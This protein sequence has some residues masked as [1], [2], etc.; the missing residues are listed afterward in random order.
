MTFSEVFA[1][2]RKKEGLSQNEMAER[3][4]VTR[5]AVSRWEC[6]E[7]TPNLETDR[8]SVV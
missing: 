5:Q 2:L 7:T 4:F 8:K 3:L 6:G 1:A